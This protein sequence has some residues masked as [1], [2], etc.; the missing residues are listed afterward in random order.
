MGPTPI[1]SARSPEQLVPS[2][3]AMEYRMD[4]ALYD[5]ISKLSPTP[6]PATDRLEEQV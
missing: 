3:A 2:L 1:I 5:R 4:D 6:P